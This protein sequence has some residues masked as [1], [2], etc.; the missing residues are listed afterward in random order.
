MIRIPQWRA[1]VAAFAFN[2]LLFGAWAA[3]VPTFRDRFDLSEAELGIVLLLLAGGAIASFAVAGA[4]SERFGPDRMTLWAMLAYGPALVLI[5]L[6]PTLPLFCMALFL[7]G[8]LHG[9]MDVAM[10]ALA[11]KV[12]E[13]LARATMSTFHAMFSLGAG[14]GAGAGYLALRADMAPAGFFALVAALGAVPAISVMRRGAPERVPVAA[15]AGA[16]LFALPHGSLLLVG[17][18][19]FGVAMGEGAMADWSA[20]YLHDVLGASEARAALGYAAFS[21]TMVAVR[22]AGDRIRGR[23]GPVATTRASGLVAASGVGVVIAAGSLPV[24]LLGFMLI[25]AGYAVVIPLVFLR[26]A[27][28]RHVPPGPA[29]ASVATLSYGGMLLGPVVVGL[30][31]GLTSLGAAF[32]VLLL[33]ALMSAALAPLLERP[34]ERT[35]ARR[36]ADAS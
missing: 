19:A 34:G 30:V 29:I 22:L 27:R 20:V 8:A 21:V 11:A 1:V 35:G 12:E 31:A 28:D 26:A 18:I 14:L 3:R 16:P 23:F 9:G 2:G 33:L 4:L 15:T 36:P 13:D 17:L 10:N 32:G 6:A 7:F 5:A 25:G 24:A